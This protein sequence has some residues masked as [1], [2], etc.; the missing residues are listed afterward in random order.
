LFSEGPSYELLYGELIEMSPE[1]PLHVRLKSKLTV[2]LAVRLPLAEINLVPDSPLR[3]AETQE[4]E[5]DLYLH[6]A[7]LDPNDVRGSDTL[8]V[9]EVADSSL[10]DDLRRK[11]ALYAEHRVPLYWVI[12]GR[13]RRTLVHRLQGAG[14]G[15]PEIVAF[16]QPLEAP[17]TDAPLVMAELLR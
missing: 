3:L 14:Y 13:G 4:P 2:W 8:L 5:P 1:G 17:G 11:A 16:D 6:P 9:V 7:A 10:V 15:E 12:D